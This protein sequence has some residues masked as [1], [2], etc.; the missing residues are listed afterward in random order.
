MYRLLLLTVM[1]MSNASS[2]TYAECDALGKQYAKVEAAWSE[3]YTDDAYLE[4]ETQRL[5]RIAWESEATKNALLQALRFS[6]THGAL[7]PKARITLNAR[8]PEGAGR[9]DE[10]GLFVFNQRPLPLPVVL[11]QLDELLEWSRANRR[12]I[13]QERQATK[14][15]LDT[16]QQELS[17]LRAE[18]E[19]LCTLPQ[20]PK[21][22][23][24][25]ATAQE[26]QIYQRFADR[27]AARQKEVYERTMND[28]ERAWI[29]RYYSKD[30]NKLPKGV[31][32]R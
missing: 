29:D 6:D 15:K 28:I 16:L 26:A 13:T 11:R 19:K 18:L 12:T 17:K 32:V 21:A 5:E 30:K 7:S 27:E 9:I 31:H 10:N 23:G 1:L 2:A 14:E 3:L 25:A 4:S 20:A 8:I 24:S 22:N